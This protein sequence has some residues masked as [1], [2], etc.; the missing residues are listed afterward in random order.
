MAGSAVKVTDTFRDDQACG[1]G[2]DEHNPNRG[3]CELRKPA[4]I[5]LVSQC[6]EGFGVRCGWGLRVLPA[7]DV[8]A[9]NGLIRMNSRARNAPGVAERFL[10]T[11]AS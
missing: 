8:F 9:A 10:P 5:E 3:A 11:D 4:A 6:R 1:D 7:D 2:T